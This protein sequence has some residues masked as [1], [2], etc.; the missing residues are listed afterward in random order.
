MS[1]YASR[2]FWVDA[3]DRAVAT[4]AQA[5]VATLTADAIPGLLNMDLTQVL[6]VS[7]LAAVVSILTSV[8]FRGQDKPTEPTV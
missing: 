6:S 1:K 7:G 2:Q 5:A 8:A 4:F 3:A